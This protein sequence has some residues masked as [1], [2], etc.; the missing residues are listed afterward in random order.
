MTKRAY[1]RFYEELNDFLPEVL[2][3]ST[4]EQTFEVSPSVKDMIESLGVPHT[5]IDLIIVNGASVDFTHRVDDGD[6][7]GVYPMFEAIDIS[8]VVRLRPDPLRV[9]RFSVDANLGRLAR[10]LRLLGF[11]TRYDPGSS[12]VE[13]AV[14]SQEER[15]LLL[16]RDVGLLKRRTITHGSFVRAVD[17]RA[18]LIEVLARFDLAGIARPF[19]RCTWCNGDLKPVEKEAVAGRVPAGSLERFDDFR[20]CVSCG[21]IYWEGSHIERATAFIDEVLRASRAP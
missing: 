19:T 12:D 18:Q 21:R 17:P 13:L 20:A 7:V 3:Y 16:T 8:P 2:R 10:Y 11:D 15:R 6:R 4:I 5:E 14:S 1:F 9:P